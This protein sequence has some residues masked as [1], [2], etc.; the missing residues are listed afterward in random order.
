VGLNSFVFLFFSLKNI[1]QNLGYRISIR[2]LF[3]MIIRLLSEKN[4]LKKYYLIL[5]DSYL[6]LSKS[7]LAK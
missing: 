3:L 4:Y 7:N 1:T 6:I 2:E 5:F